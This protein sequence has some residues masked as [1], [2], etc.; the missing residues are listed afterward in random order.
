MARKN[1]RRITAAYLE[2][3]VA[4][5]LE[6]YFTTR[7]HLRSLL[8]KRVRRSAD[9][10][11]TDPEE[12]MVLVDELLERLEQQGIMNDAVYASS[13]ARSQRRKGAS[14]RAIRAKLASKGL[15]GPLV[16]EALANAAE[17][18][19]EGRDPDLV[20]AAQWARKKR[21]GPWTRDPEQRQE[22]RQKQLARLGRRGFSWGIASQ[23]I[24]AELEELEELLW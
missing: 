8:A 7:S 13:V 18:L 5:Y 2:R 16:D 6:R 15:R 11:G 14:E 10:H 12:G 3:V 19:S 4:H 21:L 20:A 1:P 24:D 22:L 9:H 17:E 23:V